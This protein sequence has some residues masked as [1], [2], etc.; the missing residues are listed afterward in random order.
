MQHTRPHLNPLFIM[1]CLPLDIIL[2]AGSTL[3]SFHGAGAGKDDF[4]SAAS[5]GRW[6]NH[7]SFF[8]GVVVLELVTIGSS[9]GRRERVMANK[10]LPPSPLVRTIYE[11]PAMNCPPISSL[12]LACAATLA[13]C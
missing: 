2:L 1:C 8:S 13:I 9:K 12:A 10:R 4:V 5:E 3:E 6:L 7:S 11:R